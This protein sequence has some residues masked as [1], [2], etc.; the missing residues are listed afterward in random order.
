MKVLTGLSPVLLICKI[1]DLK[2]SIRFI[3]CIHRWFR[4]LPVV[5]LRCCSNPQIVGS[6][7][8]NVVSSVDSAGHRASTG[9]SSCGGGGGESRSCYNVL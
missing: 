5:Q 6:I 3:C 2:V 4:L 9:G 1:N 7:Y 8:N